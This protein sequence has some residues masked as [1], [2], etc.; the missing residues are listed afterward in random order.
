[1]LLKFTPMTSD[2]NLFLCLLLLFNLMFLT[3]I[4]ICCLMSVAHSFSVVS[5]LPLHEYGIDYLFIS[6]LWM[7]SFTHSWPCYE[8]SCRSLFVDIC[9]HL[10]S[11][12]ILNSTQSMHTKKNQFEMHQLKCSLVLQS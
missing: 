4:H 12:N 7:D 6:V 10:S 9:Y 2:I 11:T 5:A 3:F 8:Y 1:M